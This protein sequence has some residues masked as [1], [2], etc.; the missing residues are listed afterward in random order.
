MRTIYVAG[1]PK[2]GNTWLTRLL[3]DVGNCPSG[4]CRPEDDHHEPA[5]EGLDRPSDYVVRKGHFRLVGNESGEVVPVEHRLAWRNITDEG[6]VFIYRDPRDIILSGA[7]YWRRS[8]QEQLDMVC[9]GTGSMRLHG[10]WAEYMREWLNAELF[11][12]PTEGFRF[13]TVS[14]EDLRKDTVGEVVRILMELNVCL[15]FPLKSIRH[16]VERQSFKTR[17]A[18]MKKHGDSLVFGDKKFHLHSMPKGRVGDW[19]KIF[20]SPTCAAIEYHLGPEMRAVG[21]TKEAQWWKT[22]QLTS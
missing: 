19:R 21:Y 20:D 17:K 9:K 13:A 11:E 8:W 10:S 14:Y 15:P 7:D 16:A 6:V 2:S 12:V 3:A 18:W 5:T 4:G 22:P 1:Y